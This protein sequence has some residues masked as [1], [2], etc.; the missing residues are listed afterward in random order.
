MW[1]EYKFIILLLEFR[2]LRV[3][4]FPC[5]EFKVRV[6][7]SDLLSDPLKLSLINCGEGII[8]IGFH[9]SDS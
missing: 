4:C 7:K 8:F 1:A 9:F 2:E 5:S 3:K 6:L